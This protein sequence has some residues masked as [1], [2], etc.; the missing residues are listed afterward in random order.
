MKRIFGIFAGGASLTL[1]LSACAMGLSSQEAGEITEALCALDGQSSISQADADRFAELAAKF[2][3]SDSLAFEGIAGSL[4]DLSEDLR[5]L[6]GQ[7]LPEYAQDS[8]TQAC[9]AAQ[10]IFG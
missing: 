3:E 7:E 10:G 6:A 9:E 8:I 5:D 1:I 2:A 4:N